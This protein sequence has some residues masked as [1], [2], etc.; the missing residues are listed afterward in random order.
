MI[1]KRYGHL[2]RLSEIFKSW[3]VTGVFSDLLQL[4]DVCTELDAVKPAL[5]DIEIYKMVRGN[6]VVPRLCDI[7]KRSKIY[8]KKNDTEA[9]GMS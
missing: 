3:Y 9:P 8:E 1:P 6:D 4:S 7:Q 2:T 5:L